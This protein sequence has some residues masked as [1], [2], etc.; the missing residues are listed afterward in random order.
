MTFVSD[1]VVPYSE[2][3]RHLKLDYF[4]VPAFAERGVLARNE[5][6]IWRPVCMASENENEVSDPEM[7]LKILRKLGFK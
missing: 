3:G 4:D 1:A 5:K 7:I 2:N 6:G